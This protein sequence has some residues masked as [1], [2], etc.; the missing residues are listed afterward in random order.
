MGV[1]EQIMHLL[2]EENL[3]SQYRQYVRMENY[4]EVIAGNI[5]TA[6][7]KKNLRS[8]LL[9]WLNFI[10]CKSFISDKKPH[11]WVRGFNNHNKLLL[12]SKNASQLRPKSHGLR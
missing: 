8:M 10:H 7:L 1:L 5:D 2:V 3:T 9:N 12:A 4:R 6:L 11:H